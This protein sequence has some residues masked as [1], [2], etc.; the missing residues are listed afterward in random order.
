MI[1]IAFAVELFDANT[2]GNAFFLYAHGEP[3]NFLEVH[4]VIMLQRA[5]S[6]DTGGVIPL[7]DADSSAFQ[8]LHR[9]NAGLAVDE[10][11]S[12]AK[13]AIGK[14]RNG[15]MRQTLRVSAHPRGKATV[16]RVGSVLVINELPVKSIDLHRA[17]GDRDVRVDGRLAKVEF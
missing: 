6:P 13:L 5:A 16:P 2:L 15:N 3:V 10:D 12:K 9:L 11:I 17:V 7:H 14:C 1:G 8:I 4:A